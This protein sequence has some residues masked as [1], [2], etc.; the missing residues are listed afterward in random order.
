[1]EELSVSLGRIT[2][3]RRLADIHVSDS[4]A[5]AHLHAQIE[6][7]VPH[8]HYVLVNHSTNGTRLKTVEADE[9]TEVRRVHEYFT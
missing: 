2:Y 9:W 5:V 4:L 1:M 3:N 8:A 7:R 6:F